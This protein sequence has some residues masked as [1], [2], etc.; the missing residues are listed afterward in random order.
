MSVHLEIPDDIVQAIRLPEDQIEQEICRELAVAF[1]A[2]GYISFSKARELANL[3]KF[4]FGRLL[5]ERGIVRHYGA[6]ELE[7]DITYASGQ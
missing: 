4:E 3:E 2:K 6:E 5:G 7:D 1:Y